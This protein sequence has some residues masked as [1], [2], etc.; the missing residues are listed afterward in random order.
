M[1]F[2]IY[3][4]IDSSRGN[5]RSKALQYRTPTSSQPQ[6]TPRL[7]VP[8]LSRP[9]TQPPSNS[10]VPSNSKTTNKP[11]PS[12][13]VIDGRKVTG[14]SRGNEGKQGILIE[15]NQNIRANKYKKSETSISVSSITLVTPKDGPKTKTPN[16]SNDLNVIMPSLNSNADYV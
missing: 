2:S 14:S 9:T 13:K 1:C 10:I 11:Q 12:P 5:T 4:T 16:D 8:K 15:Y 6:L 7:V 3:K